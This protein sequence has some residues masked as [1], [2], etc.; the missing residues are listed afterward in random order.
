[1]QI[2]ISQNSKSIKPDAEGKFC[3]V[4]CGLYRKMVEPILLQGRNEK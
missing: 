4:D 1:M 2:V 3:R